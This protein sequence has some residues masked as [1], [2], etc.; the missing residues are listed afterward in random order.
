M[1]GSQDS[2][3]G[4][5]AAIRSSSLV[6]SAQ[7]GE[8]W[9]A[10]PDLLDVRIPGSS[11]AWRRPIKLELGDLQPPAGAAVGYEASVVHTNGTVTMPI[12]VPGTTAREI[13]AAL[14][15]YPSLRD[16][17]AVKQGS[18]GP[19]EAAP[20]EEVVRNENRPDRAAIIGLRC[21]PVT[22]LNEIWNKTREFAS[23]VEIAPGYRHSKIPEFVGYALPEIAG[24]ACPH[25]L[26]LWWSILLGLSSLTR[27]EPAAWSAAIDLDA[28][29]LAVPLEQVLDIAEERLPNRILHVLMA[30]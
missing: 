21:P 20:G 18:Q 30:N 24:A 11:A 6:A 26:M 13:T 1:S 14:A 3:H 8:L 12:D 7:L 2:Y 19:E 5:A 25:P 10:N 4:T 23:V 29:E 9:A 22:T 17:F 16:A 15:G 27:Y 28:S